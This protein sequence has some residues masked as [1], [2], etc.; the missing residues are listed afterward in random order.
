MQ[1]GRGGISGL[2]RGGSTVNLQCYFLLL[3]VL[4]ILISY[5]NENIDLV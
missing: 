5:E 3:L 1:G 4:I 2:S